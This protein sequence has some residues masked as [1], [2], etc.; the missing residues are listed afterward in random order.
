[1]AMK[2]RLQWFNKQTDN[3]DADEYSANFEDDDIILNALGLH[4]EPQI[5]AGGF[6]VLPNWIAILQPY[7][8]QVIEPDLFYYQISFLYQGAWPPPPKQSKDES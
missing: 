1:M 2:V 4:E 3:L 5:Y 6:D 8:R 7:F